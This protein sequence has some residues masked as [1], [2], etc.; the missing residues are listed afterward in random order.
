[1][2]TNKTTPAKTTTAARKATTAK[3]TV[4]K[5]ATP[6]KKTTTKAAPA[7][8]ATA[9]VISIKAAT[10]TKATPVKKTTVGKKA[11]A[12]VTTLAQVRAARLATATTA[13]PVTTFP[14]AQLGYLDVA[15]EGPLGPGGI[16]HRPA[17]YPVTIIDRHGRTTRDYL[18]GAACH[19]TTSQPVPGSDNDNDN[20]DNTETVPTVICR[21]H[22]AGWVQAHGVTRCTHDKCW[23]I[24]P[25]EVEGGQ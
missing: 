2:T 10:A 24:Q 12:K 4:A 22:S 16:A 18:T 9:P 21:I 1:M 15:L 14:Q 6:V 17:S 19:P 8:P 7:K 23:P 3:A 20:Q 5:K 11:P 25:N 13:M